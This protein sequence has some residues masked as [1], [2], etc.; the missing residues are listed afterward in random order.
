MTRFR[1]LYK[2]PIPNIHG[3]I[4]S[5]ATS[6]VA[7][8]SSPSLFHHTGTVALTLSFVESDFVILKQIKSY[9]FSI[10]FFQICSQIVMMLDG[11]Y[12]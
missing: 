8:S 9:I 4:D 3:L 5:Q 2:L 10:F 6:V 1:R 12:Y 7:A 11:I